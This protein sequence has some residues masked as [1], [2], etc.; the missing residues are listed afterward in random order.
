MIGG[1]MR[2]THGHADIL[3]TQQFF[4]GRKIHPSHHEPTGEGMTEIMEGEIS[5]DC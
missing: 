4:D 2:I 3:M 1:E 5:K